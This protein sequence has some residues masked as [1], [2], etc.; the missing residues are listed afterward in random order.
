[1]AKLARVA[2]LDQETAGHR[3]GLTAARHYRTLVVDEL[4]GSKRARKFPGHM[5]SVS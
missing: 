2:S 4:Q 5:T 3:H 1:M